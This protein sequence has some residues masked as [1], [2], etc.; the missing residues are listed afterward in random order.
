MPEEK[1]EM[2]SQE[3]E[4]GEE[5]NA[6]T[7]TAGAAAKKTDTTAKPGEGGKTQGTKGT[8]GKE[9]EGAEGQEDE[10]LELVKTGQPIPFERFKQF[11][12]KKNSMK[13]ELEGIKA[14]FESPEVFR[15][16]LQSKGV[17]DPKILDEKMKEA[18]FEVE[19]TK[20]EKSEGEL[21]KKFAEGLDLSKQ[22]SW[23]RIVQRMAEHFAKETVKPIEGKLSDA[24]VTEWVGV[25]EAEAK[26]IA[27]GFDMT[28]GESG[29]DEGN[30]NTAV[31]MM[32]KYLN[33]HPEDTGLGHVKILRL[34]ISEKGFKLGKEQ[35]KKDA[36][37]R[38][39]GLRRSAME[40]DTQVTKEG[41]PDSTWSVAEIMA[42]RRK[43]KG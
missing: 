39:E 30:V 34:A 32:A 2:T 27:E 8:E 5:E 18:G 6:E 19:E 40:D 43:Q 37:K 38:N 13:S 33:E 9:T 15:A 28:Y 35:G 31:G 14:L 3:E 29:K 25:Q 24:K 16:I 17:T 20:D 41:S 21:Y 11:I 26:K 23:F 7:E 12:E 42:W 36:K 4:K 10:E 22:D 1:V